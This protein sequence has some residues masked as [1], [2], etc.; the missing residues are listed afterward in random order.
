VLANRR[1]RIVNVSSGAAA[2]PASMI[3]CRRLRHRQ[4]AL[5]AHTLNFAAEL[6]VSEVTVNVFRPGR[7]RLPCP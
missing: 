1:V 6:A 3:E 5:E 4:T 7:R 2:H